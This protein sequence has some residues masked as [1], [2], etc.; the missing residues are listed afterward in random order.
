MRRA[1][2]GAA[3]RARRARSRP[4][5][6]RDHRDHTRVEGRV[7]ARDELHLDPVWPRRHVRD[8]LFEAF[9]HRDQLVV[10]QHVQV[11]LV[12]LE[13]GRRR[14]H[15]PRILELHAQEDLRAVYHLAHLG[16]GDRQLAGAARALRR[17][18]RRV[19]RARRLRGVVVPAAR[20]KGECRDQSDDDAH[21]MAFHDAS[22]TNVT[23]VTTGGSKGAWS[24]A[25]NSACRRWRPGVRSPMSI[26]CTFRA[27]IERSVPSRNTWTCPVSGV[28]VVAVASTIL[29]FRTL[30]STP[31]IGPV[32]ICWGAGSANAIVAVE[33]GR[34]PEGPGHT[35]E[36]TRTDA[37][38][39]IGAAASM[40]IPP[41]RGRR[42]KPRPR[43]R[44][45]P[46]QPSTTPA[47]TSAVE[48]NS[49]APPA[50]ANTSG[51]P[52]SI[53]V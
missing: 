8:D 5:L 42:G 34:D 29:A 27:V 17:G 15:E 7:V 28:T 45:S 12:R 20:R 14:R 43:T 44:L 21:P 3:R 26:A 35:S 16:L 19:R 51:V 10:Q 39:T 23:A 33:E 41:Q 18:A 52:A 40:V 24:A 1:R 49:G 36:G 6:E 48:A 53:R 31:S 32:T 13:V 25:T 22:F 47:P 4:D 46:T 50:C 37:T 9:G 11:P 30:T 2:S 38:R